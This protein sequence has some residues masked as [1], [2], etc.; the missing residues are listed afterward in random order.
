MTV[1]VPSP[2][3]QAL[4][5]DRFKLN[6]ILITNGVNTNLFHPIP[7]NSRREIRTTLGLGQEDFC[8]CYLGS[9][10]NWLDLETVVRALATLKSLK[11]VLI[12]GAP[13]SEAYINHVLKLCEKE[14]VRDRVILTGFKPQAEAARILA[15]CDAAIVPFALRSELSAVALPDKGFEYLA[16]GL[17]VISTRL[18]DLETLFGSCVYF[19]DTVESLHSILELL[20]AGATRK[21]SPNNQIDMVRK[22]D[23]KALSNVYERLIIQLVKNSVCNRIQL[24][25]KSHQQNDA[26]GL[27]LEPERQICV[28]T[29]V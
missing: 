11:L 26:E 20:Q 13:R 24:D 25:D 2:S 23:W 4:V 7:K 29:E 3:M 22:Y 27:G 10:E 18:P 6:S 5:R 21:C 12:G 19:Y 1:V 14:G 28:G 9:I 15:S 16:T 8:L 17:P